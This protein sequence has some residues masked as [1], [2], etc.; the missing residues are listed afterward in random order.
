MKYKTRLIY[1]DAIQFNGRNIED[2]NIFQEQHPSSRNVFYE[3]NDF[4]L[5]L[6]GEV[7]VFSK[8][9]F[10]IMFERDYD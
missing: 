7:E 9:E 6:E 1:V 4:L 8:E 5:I 2:V 10:N 3:L